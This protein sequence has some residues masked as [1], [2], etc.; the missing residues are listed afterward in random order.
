MH[1]YT[2]DIPTTFTYTFLGHADTPTSRDFCA[3]RYHPANDRGTSTHA[4][5]KRK[6]ATRNMEIPVQRH[7]PVPTCT[8]TH[9]YTKDIQTHGHMQTYTQKL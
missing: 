2:S 9:V 3:Y 6:H 8:H 7:T 1:T 4:A 5:G